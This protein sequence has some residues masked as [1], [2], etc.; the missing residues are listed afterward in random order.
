MLPD[1]IDEE[2][3]FL[4]G[5]DY[6]ALFCALT[7]KANGKRKIFHN[8]ANGLQAPAC[9]AGSI[10][11]AQERTGTTSV[12]TRFCSRSSESIP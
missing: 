5:K 1:G 4:G 7:V 11:R 6:V 12:L 9:I 3:V 8:S 10:K 2:I